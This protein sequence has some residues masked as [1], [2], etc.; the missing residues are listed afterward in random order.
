MLSAPVIFQALADATRWEIVRLLAGGPRCVCELT[1]ALELPQST[2]STHLQ[3]LRAAGV[4]V[5]ERR[6]RWMYYGIVR[7][8][9]PLLR[10]LW[11]HFPLTPSASPAVC[12][13]E[14]CRKPAESTKIMV[15]A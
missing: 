1:A 2:L 11:K 7:E 15:G 4:L 5:G 13:P 8:L 14:D 9:Q 6:G 12:A 3:V 10:S